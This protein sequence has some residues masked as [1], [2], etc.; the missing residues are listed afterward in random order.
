[1]LLTRGPCDLLSSLPKKS[2]S[3]THSVYSDS[4]QSQGLYSQCLPNLGSNIT[5]MKA[6]LIISFH[7]RN[8][9]LN[10]LCLNSLQFSSVQSQRCLN[11]YETMNCSTPAFPVNHQL[12]EFAQT[13]VY[14]VSEASQPS[15]Y[16]LSPSPPTFNLSQHQGLF[17]WVSSLHQVVKVLEFQ[18][19]H[20][21]FQWMLRTDFL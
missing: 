13:Y 3:E 21:S 6:T 11:L 1:M 19:Q 20:Q 4:L 7:S 8:H 16:L 17:K 10:L 12:P 9:T 5:S 18:L 15:H 2:E 14:W